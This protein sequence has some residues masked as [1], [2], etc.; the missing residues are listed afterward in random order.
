MNSCRYPILEDYLCYV[1]CIILNEGPTA[2]FRSERGSTAVLGSERWP[3]A[4][5]GSE[6]G[7]GCSMVINRDHS[8]SRV[9]NKAHSCSRVRKR[10]HI[11]CRV[12]K[13]IHEKERDY[14]SIF[15]YLSKI[16]K[17]SLL[18]FLKSSFLSDK[19]YF[20]Q[21]IYAYIYPVIARRKPGDKK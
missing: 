10:A 19:M 20:S 15:S 1:Y 5:L 2:I 4:V 8:C 9:R 21:E 14:T 3:T 6:R 12:G 17:I 18:T 16:N 13:R 7:S 11:C